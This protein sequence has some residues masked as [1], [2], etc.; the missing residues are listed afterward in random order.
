MENYIKMVFKKIYINVE[1]L[2]QN[3]FASLVKL[4][5]WES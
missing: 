1:P 3:D 2:K 4:F 5:I